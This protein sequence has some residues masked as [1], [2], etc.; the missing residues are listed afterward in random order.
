MLSLLAQAGAFSNHYKNHKEL[1]LCNYRCRQIA[2]TI[3][4]HASAVPAGE[5]AAASKHKPETF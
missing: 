3:N 1:E 2:P 5:N 4:Q